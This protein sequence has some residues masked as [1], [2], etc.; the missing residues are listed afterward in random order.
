MRNW[1][2]VANAARARI[3]EETDKPGNYIHRADLVHAQSR[4]K[5]VELGTARAGHVK[6]SAA[7]P[8]GA[9]YEPRTNVRDHEHERFAREVA[10]TLNDG[11]SRGEC[12]GLVLVAS[13]PFLGQ[14]KSQLSPRACKAL[15]E[16]QPSD[17]TSFTDADI[18]QR[19]RGPTP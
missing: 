1:L 3:L 18:A 8:G 10:T 6:G 5:G 13:N 7:G 17:Y 9:A 2:V 11:V 12:A 16:T 4:Q 14:L 19:L 15:L